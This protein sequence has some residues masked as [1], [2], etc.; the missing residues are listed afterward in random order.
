MTA[1]DP[2]PEGEDDAA[3]TTVGRVNRLLSRD[4]AD[5]SD[6]LVLESVE[7]VCSLVPAPAGWLVQPAGGWYPHQRYGAALLAARLYRLKDSPGGSLAQ[8]GIE[9]SGFVVSSG[10]TDVAMLLGLG[11]YA[12]GRVG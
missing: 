5:T 6:P 2:T 11:T 1:P 12:V 4:P 3:L 8:F 7:A 9:G 10:W